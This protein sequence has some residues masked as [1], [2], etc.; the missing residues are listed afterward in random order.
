VSI[1]E[2]LRAAGGQEAKAVAVAG[3]SG[4]CLPAKDFDRALCYEDLG[5]NGAVI[6][7][8]PRRDMLHVAENFLEFFADESCGQCAPCRLGSVALLHGV[9]E[10]Q[11]GRCTSRHLRICAPWARPCA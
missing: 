7:F 5:T 1:K 9:R 6:V 11:R 4:P 2:V 8:G 3:A 10:M